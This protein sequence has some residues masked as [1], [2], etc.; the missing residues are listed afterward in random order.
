[1]LWLPENIAVLR[2][3]AHTAYAI[4]ELRKTAIRILIIVVLIMLVGALSCSVTVARSASNSPSQSLGTEER[5]EAERRLWELGYWAGTVDGKFDSASRHA[6]IAFQK[7][8]RRPRTGRLTPNELSALRNASRTTARYPGSGHVEIDLGRQVLF[9]IDETGMV[10]R[11]LPVS[12][13]N[14]DLYWDHGELHRAHTPTGSFKVL[15]KIKG[16]RTSSLGLLY[17]P[18][19]ILNGFAIHGSPSVPPNAASHGCIRVPMFAAKEL[20]SLLPIGTT[21][22][23][24]NSNNPT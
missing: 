19:Y 15:R 22:Y 12:T 1:M 16:W 9:L 14:G 7:V 10:V 4:R 13:G 8:E 20:S 11:V 17:H 23:I 2:E 5:L 6:L 24:Y 21:V 3:S 18:S